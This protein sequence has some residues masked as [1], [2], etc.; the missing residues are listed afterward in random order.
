MR[1]K[2]DTSGH[3]RARPYF[4]VNKEVA[5][6]WVV[7]YVQAKLLKANNFFVRSADTV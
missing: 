2:P 5:T 4:Q 1:Q 3:A 6:I 7:D